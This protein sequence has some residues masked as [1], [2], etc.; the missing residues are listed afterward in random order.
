MSASRHIPSRSLLLLL[1]RYLAVAAVV[2]AFALIARYFGLDD[3]VRLDPGA[4]ITAIDGD[5]LKS[6]DTEYRIFGIDAPELFQTCSEANGKAWNCGRA[7][8]ARLR[9][10][11]ASQTIDCEPRA[12][13]KFGRTVAICSTRSVP[14]LG[15]TLVREG[16]AI[17]F[18]GFA[19]GPYVDAEADARLAKRGIWRGH[20]D[21]PGSWRK[22]HPRQAD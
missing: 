16:L 15:E 1:A 17:N 3:N 5:T 13:D 7:A 11:I 18:S 21:R 9:A 14:D 19:E 20:F 4:R 12:R 22:A 2:V 10:L 8:Q 6:S